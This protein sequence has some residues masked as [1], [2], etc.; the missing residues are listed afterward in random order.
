MGRSQRPSPRL[1][2]SALVISAS[3]WPKACKGLVDGSFHRLSIGDI[4]LGKHGRTGDLETPPCG[5][6]LELGS[7]SDLEQALGLHIIGRRPHASRS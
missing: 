3:S 1:F 5:A 4:G 6:V 2:T 7:S